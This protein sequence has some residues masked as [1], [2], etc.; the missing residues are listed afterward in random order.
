MTP[1]WP[2]LSKAQIRQCVRERLDALLKL[3]FDELSILPVSAGE[4]LT[5]A[6]RPVERWTYVQRQSAEERRV[7]VQFGAERARGSSLGQS[8]AEGFRV[9]SDGTRVMVVAPE[10]YEFW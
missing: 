9:R 5:I 10:I 1:K 4:T 8:Y 6:D 3:T 2:T 7:I